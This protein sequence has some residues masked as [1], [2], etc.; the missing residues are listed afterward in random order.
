MVL[1][2][3]DVLCSPD[4]GV[5]AMLEVADDLVAIVRRE[6]QA[7]VVDLVEIPQD[8]VLDEFVGLVEK[9]NRRL[10]DRVFDR[11]E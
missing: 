6:Q 9:E 11:V 1:L 5:D 3:L 4:A 10:G 2:E 8:I 7:D